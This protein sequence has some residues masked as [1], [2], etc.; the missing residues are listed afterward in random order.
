VQVRN[1]HVPDDGLDRE[2]AQQPIDDGL[3]RRLIELLQRSSIDRDREWY[4]DRHTNRHA[5]RDAYWYADVDA[6]DGPAPGRRA[7][8]LAPPAAQGLE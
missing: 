1:Q 8:E 3:R 2:G 6:H 4:T 5:D 7:A